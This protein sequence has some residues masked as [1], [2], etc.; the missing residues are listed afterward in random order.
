VRLGRRRT[1]LLVGAAL[2]AVS[3]TAAGCAGGEEEDALGPA[4]A[5]AGKQ[6]F[7]QSCGAC[8][9]MEDAGTVGRIGPD[10]DDAFRAARQAGFEE[11][12]F[13]GVTLRWIEISQAPMPRNIVTGQDALDVSQYVAEF[14]G[15]EE[16]SSVRSALPPPPEEP[17]I[18]TDD[19]LRRSRFGP[20]VNDVEGV[21]PAEPQ[22]GAQEADGGEGDSEEPEGE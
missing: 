11:S 22:G 10:M 4:D 7:I 12:Q 5:E 14:A 18:G 2:A 8:H 20:L 15:L 13:K 6:I 21:V 17:A 9:V 1:T 3:L 19:G 16:D